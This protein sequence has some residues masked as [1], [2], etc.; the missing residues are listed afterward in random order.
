MQRTAVYLREVVKLGHA[1]L[2]SVVGHVTRRMTRH[3]GLRSV[4]EDGRHAGDAKE[5]E[6]ERTHC[7]DGNERR[8]SGATGR[9]HHRRK[10]EQKSNEVIDVVVDAWPLYHVVDERTGWAIRW[11]VRELSRSIEDGCLDAERDEHECKDPDGTEHTNGDPDGLQTPEQSVLYGVDF[12]L[13]R[14]NGGGSTSTS[15]SHAFLFFANGF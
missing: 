8:H 6:G 15:S 13:Q 14:G 9:Q 2:A 3:V 11:E 1:T 7:R 5:H 10:Q 12:L 4:Q